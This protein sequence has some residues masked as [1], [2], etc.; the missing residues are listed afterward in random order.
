MKTRITKRVLIFAF[1]LLGL[2]A[3]FLF[4]KEQEKEKKVG[5]KDVPELVKKTIEEN[6][7]GGKVDEIEESK[8]NG[9]I[10]YEVDIKL[11]GTEK[12]LCISKDGKLMQTKTDDEEDDDEDD[13]GDDKEDDDDDEVKVSISELPQEVLATAEKFLGEVKDA[14]AS[15]EKENGKTIYEIEITKDGKESSADISED[16]KIL[17]IEKTISKEEIPAPIKETFEKKF[18]NKQITEITECQKFENDQPISPKIYEIKFV[19]PIT[20]EAEFDETG[21]L[22]SKNYEKECKMKSECKGKSMGK[23]KEKDDN[24]D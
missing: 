15:K 14:Q 3:L 19:V 24:K 9:E 23:H 17:E 13:E 21:K 5:L 2:S 7:N 20:K 18:K 16:G 11:N 1:V 8:C 12:E 6:L 4:A 10:C 22:I